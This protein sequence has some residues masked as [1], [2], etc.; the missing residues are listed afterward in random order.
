M[1]SF[2]LVRVLFDNQNDVRSI[3]YSASNSSQLYEL[4]IIDPKDLPTFILKD[5]FTLRVFFVVLR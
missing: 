4:Q 1:V 2:M 3:F 5:Y